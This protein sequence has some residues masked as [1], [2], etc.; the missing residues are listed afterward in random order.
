MPLNK[1]V[2]ETGGTPEP[3][4]TS[5]VENLGF[6]RGAYSI[7]YDEYRLWSIK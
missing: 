4:R 5:C 3:F 1:I 2:R 6:K 7:I